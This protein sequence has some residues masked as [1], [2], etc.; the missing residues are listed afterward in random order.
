MVARS[1][2]PHAEGARLQPKP[3]P[4]GCLLSSGADW[5][6]RLAQRVQF[7]VRHRGAAVGT[8]GGLVEDG[9]ELV[10]L[11]VHPTW[12]G[13]AW[14]TCWCRR[15][16]TGHGRRT[17]RR[18]GC[19]S[20]P[21]I[22]RPSACMRDAASST[23]ARAAGHARRPDASGGRHGLRPRPHP[24]QTH[25]ASESRSPLSHGQRCPR[26]QLRQCPLPVAPRRSLGHRA[27]CHAPTRAVASG[28]CR[29]QP[30]L[31]AAST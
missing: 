23:Q 9:A 8:V 30:R 5:R 18:C 2:S 6:A 28:D 7:V 16:W 29:A 27:D 21:T 20:P 26:H 19:G 4:S 14:G 25:A 10:S 13:L 15:C 1:P 12:R 3:S 11:W 24:H 22:D 31:I 17:T